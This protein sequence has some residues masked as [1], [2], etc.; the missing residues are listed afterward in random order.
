MVSLF[1]LGPNVAMDSR[2]DGVF[3]HDKADVT[4]IAYLLQAATFVKDVIGILSDDTGVFVML[5]Y[6]VWKIQ[7]HCSVEMEGWNGVVVDINA[8]CTEL[9]P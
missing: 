6:W 2:D 8:T 1:N 4:T 7:L 5:A 9:G 3:T